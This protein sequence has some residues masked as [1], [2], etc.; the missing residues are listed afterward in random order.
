MCGACAGDDE[1]DG[2]MGPYADSGEGGMDNNWERV[3]R[4]TAQAYGSR[5]AKCTKQKFHFA[6]AVRGMGEHIS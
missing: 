2:T 3:H 5:M 6:Q 4:V 1:E